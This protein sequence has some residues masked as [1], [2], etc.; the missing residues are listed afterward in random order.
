MDEI[1]TR[2]TTS[3]T[4]FKANPNKEVKAAGD[5][6]FCVLTNNRPAFYVLSPAA[7]EDLEELIWELE[8]TPEVLRRKEEFERTGKRIKV[9]IEDLL[10]GKPIEVGDDE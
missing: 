1:L 3:I 5:Q 2:L 9:S 6:P 7:W 4:T 10:A 8:I